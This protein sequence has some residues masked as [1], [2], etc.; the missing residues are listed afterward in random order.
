MLITVTYWPLYFLVKP[1]IY[2]QN[3][4]FL[5]LYINLKHVG[6]VAILDFKDATGLKLSYIYIFLV[7]LS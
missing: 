4:I 7:A 3:E 6:A 2:R 1:R 5:Y